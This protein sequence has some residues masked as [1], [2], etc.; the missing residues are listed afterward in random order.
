MTK[1]GKEK[2]IECFKKEDWSYLEELTSA[3]EMN[4][5]F[6]ARVEELVDLH[7][8]IKSFSVKDT[9]DPWITDWL[10]NKI[11]RRNKE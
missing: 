6:Q 7:F 3:D 1:K 9:D 4:E 10:R 8:P 11:K 5:Y 2:F